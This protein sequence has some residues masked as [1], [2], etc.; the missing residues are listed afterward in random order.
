MDVNWRRFFCADLQEVKSNNLVFLCA[1]QGLSQRSEIQVNRGL[2]DVR[3]NF[4]CSHIVK[5]Q[6]LTLHNRVGWGVSVSKRLINWCFETLEIFFNDSGCR[7][8]RRLPIFLL[9][10]LI[11]IENCFTSLDRNRI[12][13]KNSSLYMTTYRVGMN[14]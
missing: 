5:T 3:N 7:C 12:N 6:I 8:D 14:G 10:P 11:E 2:F 4:F 9:V 1:W 13:D